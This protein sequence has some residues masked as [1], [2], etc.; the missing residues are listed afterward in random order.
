MH[1]PE[2][3][4]PTENYLSVFLRHAME[5][6]RDRIAA[7]ILAAALFALAALSGAPARAEGAGDVDLVRVLAANRP[8]ADGDLGPVEVDG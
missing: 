7:C 1:N 3:K 6:Y 8:A 4:E 5:K 2:W